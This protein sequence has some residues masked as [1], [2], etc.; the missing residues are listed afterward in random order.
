MFDRSGKWPGVRVKALYPDAYNYYLHFS[1]LLK[2]Y[3]VYVYAYRS[4]K[5]HIIYRFMF[6]FR[7]LSKTGDWRVILDIQIPDKS[8][9]I[10]SGDLADDDP[11]EY[12]IEGMVYPNSVQNRGRYI[13]TLTAYNEV[14][15]I[16]K[17][18]T[19]Q[20]PVVLG[21]S[22][23]YPFDDFIRRELY[24]QLGIAQPEET[25][26]KIDTAACQQFMANLHMW[27]KKEAYDILEAE[28]RLKDMQNEM[29][30]TEINEIRLC[31]AA[32]PIYKAWAKTLLNKY[33]GRP[34]V[35]DEREL[36]YSLEDVNNVHK[37]YEVAKNM[38]NKKV[39]ENEKSKMVDKP[40]Y[41]VSHLSVKKVI[42]SNPVTTV[43]W[44]DDTKTQVRRQKGDKWDMEKALAMAICKKTLG[45]TPYFNN[46][47][48]KWLAEAKVEDP[49][50]KKAEKKRR[51]EVAK[52]ADVMISGTTEEVTKAIEDSK[53]NILH[54][55]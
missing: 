24:N 30:D 47:F 31:A 17:E 34:M 1:N 16:I 6:G 12:F 22:T 13:S 9:K 41:P 40:F 55:S 37:L 50:K 49:K 54:T 29:L 19:E 20:K 44:N 51:K 28:Q 38:K 5:S 36:R 52:L 32:N 45:N 15:R 10:I 26:F 8:S 27:Q 23:N 43:I 3:L 53:K 7:T 11:I 25:I 46:Y 2:D 33:F 35:C 48:K 4:L 14:E 18:Y 42:F 39:K 21:L